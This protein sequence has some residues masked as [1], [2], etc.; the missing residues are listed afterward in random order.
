[1]A[2]FGD[3]HSFSDVDAS[4]DVA[5]LAEYLVSIA[6]VM[7]PSR[8]AGL[9]RL[10]LRP[11]MRLLDAGCGVG[12]VAI[13]AARLVAPNGA[14]VGID[15]SV[16]LVG[17]ARR[18]AEGTGLDVTFEVGDVARLPFPDDTFDA[19]RCERVFQHLSEETALAATS[20]LIRVVR[21]GGRIQLVDPVHSQHVLDCADADLFAMLRDRVC[22][23]SHDPNSGI[24]LAGRLSAAGSKDVSIDV[25]L[26]WWRRLDPIRRAM[27]FDENL[28]ALVDAGVIDAERAGSFLV[29]LA[30]RETVG[31]L[32]GV[33]VAYCATAVKVG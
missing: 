33:S 19:A 30:S 31:R 7:A 21:P 4:S 12:D 11:G 1:M 32:Y 8:A 9:A 17:R 29:D 6:D 25:D 26:I 3:G 14:A 23:T 2:T 28:R 22:A 20:E 5:A 10:G 13:S 16:E 18:A 24:R 27:G 15:L